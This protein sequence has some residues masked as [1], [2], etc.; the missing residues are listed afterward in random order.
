MRILLMSTGGTIGSS[1]GEVVDIEGGRAGLLPRVYADRKD[2]TAPEVEFGFSEPFSILSENMTLPRLSELLGAIGRLDLADY[3]GVIVTHGSD[4]L[5]YTA[6]FVGLLFGRAGC[7]IVLVAAD[8]PLEDPDGNG[9]DNFIGAVTLIASGQVKSGVFVVYRSGTVTEVF[10]ATRIREADGL[11][12]IFRPF[13][14]TAFGRI[15]S[16]RFIPEDAP[17]LPPLSDFS[18]AAAGPAPS[19]LVFPRPVWMLKG[20]PGF[21]YSALDLTSPPAAVLQ[22]GYHSGTACTEGEDTSFLRFAARLKELRVPV[23]V[24][25]ARRPGEKVYAS[26]QAMLA[27]GCRPLCGISPE[28]AYAKLCIGYNL[29]S[30]RTG[31]YL[32]ENIFYEYLEQNT[33]GLVGR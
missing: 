27:A 17:G 23:Y 8:R 9:P 3:D 5:S 31:E 26:T 30:P 32:A 7:P 1:V 14:D 20:Y 24:L 25:P 16:G 12:G 29:F 13:G 2:L 10:L 22:L 15:E 6:A 4:T 19:E 33:H 11:H 18:D 21:V 28:A